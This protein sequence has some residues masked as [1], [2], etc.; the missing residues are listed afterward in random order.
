MLFPIRNHAVVDMSTKDFLR[1][2]SNYSKG[3]RPSMVHGKGT[4]GGSMLS[5]SPVSDE[6][7]Q[8]ESVSTNVDLLQRPED[9]RA[10]T[11]IMREILKDSV[12]GY[13]KRQNDRVPQVE[14]VTKTEKIGREIGSRKR[15][16]KVQKA[17]KESIV[18]DY[19]KLKTKS[20]QT[21]FI[22]ALGHV[23]KSDPENSAYII[24]GIEMVKK[25]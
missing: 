23:Y 8:I 9:Y 25:L 18:E 7:A 3:D 15:K 11:G 20:K 1:Q 17:S 13:N 4:F 10:S 24:E 16:T 2:F 5:V 6:G 22:E 21:K 19:K 12:S 14:S